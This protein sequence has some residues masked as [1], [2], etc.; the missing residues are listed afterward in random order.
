MIIPEHDVQTELTT[1][2]NEWNLIEIPVAGEVGNSHLLTSNL[3]SDAKEWLV[4][5]IP[6][7]GSAALRIGIFNQNDECLGSILVAPA[8]DSYFDA[9]SGVSKQNLT[10][11]IWISD[12]AIP[13]ADYDELLPCL[14]YL[15]LRHGRIWGRKTVVS[16]INP[17]GSFSKGLLGLERLQK[18]ATVTNPYLDKPEESCFVP[19]VQRLD[20]TLHNA[21]TSATPNIQS[22]LR[23]YFVPEAVATLDRWINNFLKNAWFQAVYQGTLTRQQYIYSLSNIYQ[24]VRFTTRLIGRAVA[25]SSQRDL[26]KFWLNHLQ[27]EIDHEVIIEQDLKHLGADVDYV[28]NSMISIVENQEF[29]VIQES[30]LA[31]YQDP[32]IFMAAPFVVESFGANLDGNFID[33]LEATAQGWGVQNPK[34]VTKFLSSHINYDG[35]DDGHWEQTREI[36]SQFLIDN[37]QIQSFLNAMHLAM[38]SFERSYNAYIEDLAIFDCPK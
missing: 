31:F 17:N 19:V 3:E 21:Y 22:F 13:H 6:I 27:G 10:R 30:I 33:A 37:T 5:P 26:R 23:Q 29:M 11:S 9:W 12:I 32:I 34:L 36:L 28:V 8:E 15:A 38:N 4:H 25:L 35:G 18:G 2:V 16:Y 1:I 20:I 7:S 24:Y 14:V